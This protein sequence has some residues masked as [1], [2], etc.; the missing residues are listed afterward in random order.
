[1]ISSKI[2][3]DLSVLKWAF[4][5][6]WEIDRRN[7]LFWAVICT[8]GAVLP[9]L[10]LI[11]TKRIVDMITS[12]AAQLGGFGTIV[13]WIGALV[14]FLFLNAVFNMLPSIF[15]FTLFTRYAVGMQKQLGDMMRRVPLRMFDDPELALKIDMTTPT[16]K[17]LSYFLTSV[18]KLLAETVALISML[19]LAASTSWILL[20]F[21]VILVMTSLTMGFKNAVEGNKRW[22]D[23][24]D[25]ERL[26]EYYYSQVFR[27]DI[28]MEYRML[29]LDSFIR[30]KWYDIIKPMQ[31]RT[32]AFMN[33]ANLR[34]NSSLI[35]STLF[36]CALIAAGL[37][38]TAIGR[39][40]VGTLVMF[41]ATFDHIAGTSMGY[42]RLFMSSYRYVKDFELQKQFFE[43]DFDDRPSSAIQT[44]PTPNERQDKPVVFELQGVSFKYSSASNDY[45]L[46]DVSLKIHQG[47]MIALVGGNGAG[48]STLVKV[49]L[50]FYK[51][52]EGNV[53]FEGKHYDEIDLSKLAARMGVTFQDFA[54][55]EFTLRENIAFGDLSKLHD[56]AALHDA[57]EK[58]GATKI[59]KRQSSGLDTHLGRWYHKNAIQLSGGEWQRIAVSRAHISSRDI[60]I[61]DEP[62]AML[63][64]IAEMEQFYHIRNSIQN[65]TGVL[66]SHRIG[67][68]RLADKVAVMDGGRLVEFGTH[69]ELMAKQGMYHKLF[70]T[71]AEWYRK[72]EAM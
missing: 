17:R 26:A 59:L 2:K 67:F 72:E 60:L 29:E 68:A 53:F 69:D 21:A 16:I 8:V 63:D 40:T 30:K 13:A 33:K 12:E 5:K 10:F 41:V 50:G 20:L 24:G 65:R 23:E 51:P 47:E 54:K 25:N 62:A 55:F 11:V 45:A 71:Q 14:G 1:M 34:T 43:M 48:K 27:N 46:K 38:L 42:G 31:E 18:L 44:E 58:G 64:P 39:I 32:L 66:I 15:D 7:L 3:S 9:V 22:L 36:K 57:A 70:M 49:L 28:A 6:A 61:M 19:V 4:Q 35:L 37:Y 52:M 56:D